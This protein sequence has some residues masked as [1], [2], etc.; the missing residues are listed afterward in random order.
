MK[1]IIL[2]GWRECV[3]RARSFQERPTDH[4][5]VL[6]RAALRMKGVLLAFALAVGAAATA[7]A[8]PLI[9]N[10]DSSWL[11]TNAAPAATWNTNPSFDTTGWINAYVVNSPVSPPDPCFMGASCIW[12]DNQD[13]AT[14]FAWLRKTF[15]ISDSISAASLFGGIDDD[16]DVYVNGTLVFASHDGLAGSFIPQPLDVTAYL[17]PGLNLIAVAVG[18]NFGFGQNHLFAAQLQV[19][20]GA[21]EPASLLLLV[22][23]LAGLVILRRRKR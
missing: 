5:A 12:Y 17:V 3:V 10:T 18:D 4:G 16:G 20:T 21:P 11:A 9:I 14:Q 19:Q 15:V 2:V 22:A 13:S 23:G 7:T 8:A 1:K 6:S